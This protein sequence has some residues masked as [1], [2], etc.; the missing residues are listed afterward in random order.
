MLTKD[1][2]PKILLSILDSGLGIKV[3]DQ[4]KLFKL[5]GRLK[6]NQKVNTK[7][8]G[9]GLSITKMNC[10]EFGGSTN[11]HSKR[12]RG[13]VFQASLSL[14][15]ETTNLMKKSKDEEKLALLLRTLKIKQEAKIKLTQ[16][17]IEAR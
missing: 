5:F 15:S 16:A 6:S 12:H 13:S 14:I 4:M 1:T 2:R 3:V 11:V 7:G 10:E 8:V 9:L 17:L